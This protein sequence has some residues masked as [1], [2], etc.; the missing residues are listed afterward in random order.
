MNF[1]ACIAA[2]WVS[3]WVLES[4]FCIPPTHSQSVGGSCIRGLRNKRTGSNLVGDKLC[5]FS[6][7]CHVLVRAA[8]AASSPGAQIIKM[9]LKIGP[10]L[11]KAIWCQVDAGD[12][13]CFCALLL[14]FFETSRKWIQKIPYTGCYIL[15]AVVRKEIT[16]VNY[17]AQ[18]TIIMLPTTFFILVTSEKF[19]ICF[20]LR[21]AQLLINVAI[22]LKRRRRGA[23]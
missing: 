21:V 3:T 20:N 8:S 13:I 19:C 4:R 6:L 11:Q 22:K 1:A 10:S 23:D 7:R 15:F 2:R 5:N 18:E 9:G 17:M 12:W 14:K 16:F